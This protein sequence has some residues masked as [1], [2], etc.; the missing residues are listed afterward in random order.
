M[1]HRSCSRD[2]EPSGEANDLPSH[3]FRYYNGNIRAVH[4]IAEGGEDLTV[5]ETRQTYGWMNGRESGVNL[6]QRE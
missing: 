3:A 4:I 6:R 1:L 5:R 2:S